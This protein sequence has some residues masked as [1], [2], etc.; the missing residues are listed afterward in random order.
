[1]TMH[2]AAMV[3]ALTVRDACK[4]QTENGRPI[5]HIDIEVIV[6]QA[7]RHASAC[8]HCPDDVFAGMVKMIRTQTGCAGAEAFEEVL[9][10]MDP[11]RPLG[12]SRWR[13]GGWYVHGV[14]YPS[15]AC[16]CVSNHYPD[17]KWRIACDDRRLALNEPGDVTF[18]TREEAACAERLLALEAWTAAVRSPA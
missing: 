9:R 11:A 13:H 7:I 3:A 18:R 1:M 15:G 6:A 16:G 17:K 2:L 8:L 4:H 12:F 5:D 10:L 14:R